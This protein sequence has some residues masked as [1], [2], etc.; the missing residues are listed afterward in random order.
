MSVQ[1]YRALLYPST[2]TERKYS[3]GRLSDYPPIIRPRTLPPSKIQTHPSPSWKRFLPTISNSLL[4]LVV[5]ST[6][7]TTTTVSILLALLA[8]PIVTTLMLASLSLA[9]M[10]VLTESS[11]SGIWHHNRESENR[12]WI[13]VTLLFTTSLLFAPD[14]PLALGLSH[15]LL[16]LALILASALYV[17][18][19]DRELSRTQLLR[20]PHLKRVSS[21]LLLDQQ[22]AKDK[23]RIVSE[24]LDGLDYRFVLLKGLRS[25][26][27]TSREVAIVQTFEEATEEELE[28]LV[29]NVNLSLLFYKMKDRDVMTWKASTLLSRTRI[30]HLLCITKLPLL[31]TAARVSL[32]DAL[33]NLRLKAH[34]QAEEW[35]CNIIV[36]THGRGLTRLKTACD[37]KGSIS[38]LHKLIFKDISNPTI[39]TS[40]LQHI[41]HE[42]SLLSHAHRRKILSDVDDTLFSSGGKFPAGIDMSY[43]VRT[44]YPGVLTF[45]KELDLGVSHSGEWSEGRLGNLVFLSARPRQLTPITLCRHVTDAVAHRAHTDLVLLLCVCVCA[46]TYTRTRRRARVTCTSNSCVYRRASASTAYP[47]CW[48]AHWTAAGVWCSAVTTTRWP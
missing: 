6:C 35:V 19:Y 7:V 10:F 36:N 17:N 15:P 34:L 14:S 25:A 39:R 42:A 44:V 21:V 40:I 12:F 4:L 9:I 28:Y 1:A 30:I 18:H 3:G 5:L 26:E 8:A 47:P 45:Y 13:I 29:T 43:P 2:L 31:H 46:Q 16:A 32:I 20:T 27:I 24:A 33:M 41:A 48:L 38:N 22:K 37:A 23:L 11:A